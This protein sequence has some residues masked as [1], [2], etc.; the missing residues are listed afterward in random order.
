MSSSRSRALGSRRARRG[1]ADTLRARRTAAAVAL[2]VA[3]TAVASVPRALDAQVGPDALQGAWRVVEV[4]ST[5]PGGRTI[6][7]PQPGLLLFTGRHYSY[8]LVNG[9]QPR[10][11][12][13]SGFATAEQLAAAW[14]PFAANAGTFEVSGDRMIRRPIVAKSPD[15]MGPGIYNEYTY[16]VSADTLWITTVGTETGPA[17]SP[18]TVRYVRER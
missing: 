3:V 14:S 8:T 17:R 2:A 6:A 10:P 18:T 7:S 11:V 16:R 13:P 5:G 9:D 12:P 4:V 15:A 1:G